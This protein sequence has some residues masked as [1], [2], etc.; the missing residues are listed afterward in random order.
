[1]LKPRIML[2]MT[3]KEVREGL[4]EMKTVVVPVGEDEQ[5]GYH[6]PLSVDIH[7]GVEIALRASQR[8]GCFVAPC[9]HYSFSGGTLPGTINIA[10]QTFSLVLMDIFRSLLVQGFQ[11]IVVLLGHGGTENTRAA[12]DAALDFQ[13]LNPT[14]RDIAICV[15]PMWEISPTIIK[16][17]D[18]GDYHAARFETSM[19]MYWKPELVKMDQVELDA[20]DFVARMHKDPDAYLTKQVAIESD[21]VMPR[22]AQSPEMEVGVMGD[23]TGSSAEMGKQIAD[24]CADALAELVVK[25]EGRL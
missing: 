22:F 3:V 10:P 5:H 15:V 23:P 13:R 20:P 18:D 7:N 24:E 8:S 21:Y 9:V 19:M 2:E 17:F 4:R 11:N 16:S 1:M 6:L 14:F 12:K 25:L